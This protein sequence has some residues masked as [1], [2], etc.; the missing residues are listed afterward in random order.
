MKRQAGFMGLLLLTLVI[1]GLVGGVVFISYKGQGVL[2][3]FFPSDKIAG[4]TIQELKVIGETRFTMLKNK[5]AEAFPESQYLNISNQI[6]Q[7][8]SAATLGAQYNIYKAV[9]KDMDDIYSQTKN[10]QMKEAMI[11]LK[12]YV[13]V[14]PS[15]N[16]KDFVIPK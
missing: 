14:F 13:S 12:D 3:R 10:Q 8:N 2:T 15:Y 4:K 16:S 11:E 6:T 9:F 7:A 5:I 1:L